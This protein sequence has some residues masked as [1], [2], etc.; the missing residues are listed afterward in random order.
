MNSFKINGVIKDYPPR[1]SIL[2]IS[3]LDNKYALS[4]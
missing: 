3:I 1:G 4:M 2:H